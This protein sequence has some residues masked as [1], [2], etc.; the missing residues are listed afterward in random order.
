MP[1]SE[2]YVWLQDRLGPGSTRMKGVNRVGFNRKPITRKPPGYCHKKVGELCCQ[3]DHF[4]KKAA[5]KISL[6]C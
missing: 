2:I 4:S 5:V 1:V 3:G 6:K